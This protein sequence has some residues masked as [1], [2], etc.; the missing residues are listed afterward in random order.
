METVRV[1]F[2][3]GLGDCVYF[4]HQIPLYARRGLRVEINCNSDKEIIFQSAGAEIARGPG[5]YPE[6]PWF[7]GE[8]PNQ[9][10]RFD[11]Y[12]R[13]SKLARNLSLGPMPDIGHPGRLWE[14]YCDVS[15]HA[16]QFLPAEAKHAV[17]RYVDSL[18]RPLILLH[19]HGSTDVD[20][21]NVPVETV[22]Q[23]CRELLSNTDATLLLLDWHGHLPPL[24]H[25]RIRHILY[26]FG[27]L[28]TGELLVLLDRADLMVGI[29]SGPL[30]ACRF[31]HTPAIGL[32]M[33]NGS[34]ATWSLPRSNQV[35]IAIG[36]HHCGWRKQV[37]LPFNLLGCCAGDNEL[38]QVLARTASRMLAG[39]RYLHPGF[40]GRDILLQQFVRDWQGRGDNV[41]G[42]FTDRDRGFDFLFR[43]AQRFE[44]PLIVETGCIR[45]DEDFAGAGFSTLLL[46]MFAAS[47]D[48]ELISIDISPKSC[49]LAYRNVACLGAAVTVEEG[50]S[51]DWLLHN[52]RV[53]DVLYLDSMDTNEPGSPTHGL[54]EIQAAFGSL[55]PQSMV[56]WDDT[57]YANGEFLGSG[58]LGVPWLLERGW[59]V[60]FSGH[61]TILSGGRQ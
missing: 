46:G 58:A 50:D 37:R 25:W 22:R 60:V 47:R 2:D 3:H 21:K 41:F 26:D 52:R 10:I 38:P 28:N 32:W 30:H 33:R 18:R 24:P 1:R 8:E 12:W 61:Q 45:S 53:I 34:P 6:I 56:M 49:V 44:K 27:P 42:G 35:N 19:T 57:C 13:W 7:E 43:E 59:R 51:V 14:E 54:L 29:D 55:R 4:A 5:R 36:T 48:G 16:W 17:G 20:R 31:T 23:I 9:E 40:L 15:L 39:C 11:N